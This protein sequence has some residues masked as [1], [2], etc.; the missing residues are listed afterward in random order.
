MGKLR[1]SAPLP[2]ARHIG[3]PYRLI[4]T[5]SITRSGLRPG[6][7]PLVLSY[8]A[9]V[10]SFYTLL[11]MLTSPAPY[12]RNLRRR[13]TLIIHCD[14]GAELPETAEHLRDVATPLMQR[15]GYDLT[16]IRP[17]VT[18]RDGRVYEDI[19][20]YY[21]AQGAIPGKLRRSCTPR[22]KIGPLLAATADLL[23]TSDYDTVICY[24]AGEK[25]RTE[26]LEEV[27]AKERERIRGRLIHPP[28]L[29]GKYRLDMA[30]EIHIAGYPVPVKSRCFWCIFSKTP[31]MEWLTDTH[32]DLMDRAIELEENMQRERRA[33]RT[34]AGKADINLLHRPLR[35]IR[36]RH[37]NKQAPTSNEV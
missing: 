37:L 36:D 21:I 28:L 19:T 31:E 34:A 22:F 12:W 29:L 8:G 33:A 7:R 27:P 35:E 11:M 6:E 9:G 1:P 17:R 14:L 32:P 24:D 25:H 23:G 5:G 26:R 20:A 15:H 30:E 10:D 4:H 16:I 3:P 2:K 13:L 18:A